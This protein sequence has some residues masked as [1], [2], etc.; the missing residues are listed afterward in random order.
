MKRVPL[1]ASLVLLCTAAH[2]ERLL[3]DTA[4]S[5]RFWST[6]NGAEFP[7]ATIQMN[8]LHDPQRGTC[9]QGMCQ[10]AGES[11]YAGLQWR[12]RIDQGQALGFWIWLSIGNDGGVRVLDSSG[13]WFAGGYKAQGGAWSLA[14]VPLTTTAFTH[15]WG[16][17]NDGQLHFPI[18]AV[19]ITVGRGPDQREFRVSNLHVEQA[20]IAPEER[21][22]MVVVP[23]GASGVLLEGETA[24]PV[25]KFINRTEQ[26]LSTAA[27]MLARTTAGTA[28]EGVLPVTLQAWEQKEV[29]AW[30]RLETSTPGYTQLEVSATLP[31]ARPVR[32]VSGL[33]VVPRPR[34]YGQ[35]APDCYFGIQHLNDF[36]AAE[37]LGAKA[38]RHFLFWRY[39]EVQQGQLGWGATDAAVQGAEQHHL[40]VQLTV[41]LTAP[42]WIGWDLK[43][44]LIH[45]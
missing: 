12:G 36:E 13:Q 33:A 9:L 10:F 25:V 5:P 4:R 32:A 22:R 40:D 45:I 6:S 37:R 20:T 11:R 41:V 16:G 23:S 19:L 3:L 18:T 15:H 34:H 44:S 38:L 30:I 26:P 27:H 24:A 29:P 14:Q 39:T 35:A 17:A 28:T 1:I 31:D 8:T 2:A 7:G 42:G 21:L 43:L